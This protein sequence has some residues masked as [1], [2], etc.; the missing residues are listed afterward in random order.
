MKRKCSDMH[1]GKAYSLTF[2]VARYKHL[3]LDTIIEEMLA[4]DQ[5][6]Y[7]LPRIL[8]RVF[9]S[10]VRR[11]QPWINLVGNFSYRSNLRLN[12]ELY[13]DFLRERDD[14]PPRCQEAGQGG[15]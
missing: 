9:G 4:C 15:I 10:L 13:R 14:R 11:R 6:F 1:A 12:R 5:E 3:S 7:S 8:R 2:P